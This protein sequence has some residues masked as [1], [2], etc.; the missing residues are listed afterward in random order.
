MP[1]MRWRPDPAPPD[2]LVGWGGGHPLPKNPTPLGAFGASILAPSALDARRLRCLISS[3][4]GPLFLA[5][6]HWT[7]CNLSVLLF[8]ND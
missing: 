5:I 6:H 1:R 3:V 2:P 8:G 4:Y 7:P